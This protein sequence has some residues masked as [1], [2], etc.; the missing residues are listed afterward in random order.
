MLTLKLTVV[1]R[2]KSVPKASRG[3]PDLKAC[4]ILNPSIPALMPSEAV[5]SVAAA[6]SAPCSA[7]SRPCTL[8]TKGSCIFLSKIGAEK[9]ALS[10]VTCSQALRTSVCSTKFFLI[11][12]L[13]TCSAITLDQMSVS[14]VSLNQSIF[15]PS[16][17]IKTEGKPL[18]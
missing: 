12:I 14:P 3:L 16:M 15:P 6:W 17:P 1:H 8:E 2:P 7:F 18:S 9:P 10:R 11:T 4:N 13:P 5:L